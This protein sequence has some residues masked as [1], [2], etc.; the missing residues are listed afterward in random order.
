MEYWKQKAGL[1]QAAL[2][3][4]QKGRDADQE[5]ARQKLLVSPSPMEAGVLSDKFFVNK[6]KELSQGNFRIKSKARETGFSGSMM[7]SGLYEKRVIEELEL[8]KDKADKD[9]ETKG[10]KDAYEKCKGGCQCD[11]DK[12][13][14][15]GLY[16]CR[17]CNVYK[18]QKCGVQ[19]CMK[20]YAETGCVDAPLPKKVKGKKTK[21][22]AP[23]KTTK[24]RP[25]AEM[26]SESDSDSAHGHFSESDEE[27]E[28][29]LPAKPCEY[30]IGNPQVQLIEM[31]WMGFE[32][33]Y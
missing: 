32:C 14:G 15:A 30:E 9:N 17:F 3:T 16:Y 29:E 12:C 22:S 18:K 19:V 28:L 20:K 2:D 5:A 7:G 33:L 11:G 8:S 21:A 23:K 1:V 25:R 24:K 13:L 4:T 10:R 6:Q 27:P 26:E 31:V